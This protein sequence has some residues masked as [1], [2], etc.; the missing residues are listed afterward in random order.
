M[1]LMSPGTS[2]NPHQEYKSGDA[3]PRARRGLGDTSPSQHHMPWGSSPPCGAGN[4][5]CV[6]LPLLLHHRNVGHSLAAKQ[7]WGWDLL[8]LQCW[9]PIHGPPLSSIGSLCL[10]SWACKIQNLGYG[11][12]TVNSLG[13]L[14][15]IFCPCYGALKIIYFFIFNVWASYCVF[16]SQRWYKS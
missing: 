5:A 8:H 12:L 7:P 10:Q 6:G 1:Q 2:G 13:N 3:N 14:T 16:L 9:P 15:M 4:S 11:Q